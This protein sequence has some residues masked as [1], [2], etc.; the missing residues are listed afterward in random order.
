MS[1]MLAIWEAISMP[2]LVAVWTASSPSTSISTPKPWAWR[3]RSRKNKAFNF[4]DDPQEPSS[5][6]KSSLVASEFLY[7]QLTATVSAL[8]PSDELTEAA[9]LDETSVAKLSTSAAASES[10]VD[11]STSSANMS[12]DI[13]KALGSISNTAEISILGTGVGAGVIVVNV[14]PV[15]DVLGADVV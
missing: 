12:T 9:K 7:K 5:V 8:T 1:S 13:T 10:R 11:K 6:N 3:R 15:V 2:S 4:L 14:S